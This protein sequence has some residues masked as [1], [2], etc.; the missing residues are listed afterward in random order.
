MALH[1][2][3]HVHALRPHGTVRPDVDLLHFA[4]DAALDN[5]SATAHR[6]E[7]RPLVAHLDDH[8]VILGGLVEVVEFPE[9][10]HERLLHVHADTLLHRADGDGRVDMVR[11]RNGH[12]VHAQEGA[13]VEELAVVREER[14]RVHVEVDAFLDELHLRAITR[15]VVGVAERDNVY[16]SA[17]EHRR[18]VAVA[19][20][21]HAD[22]GEAYLAAAATPRVAA[23]AGRQG[24]NARRALEESSS[25]HVESHFLCSLLFVC[26]P[27]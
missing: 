21:H 10:T 5:L 12:R 26:K 20:A 19:L 24:R 25:S 4:E 15:R 6:V 2:L 22:D 13:G 17:L 1:P 8:A 14:H 9:R 3:G 23:A 18:P 7:G 16:E 11:R 27:R